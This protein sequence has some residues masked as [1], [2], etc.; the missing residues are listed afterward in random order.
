MYATRDVLCRSADH[1]IQRTLGTGLTT[2]RPSE[3]DQA[4][5][6]SFWVAYERLRS[7][8]TR[9]KHALPQIRAMVASSP[10]Q[11]IEIGRRISHDLASSPEVQAT[12]LSE[13]ATMMLKHGDVDE[14]VDTAIQAAIAERR[15]PMSRYTS[16]PH[17]VTTMV[18]VF[19]DSG[20]P[21]RAADILETLDILDD[22]GDNDNEGT[23]AY[24]R[25]LRAGVLAL[26]DRPV[27]AAELLSDALPVLT[28]RSG[29]LYGL[30]L[31]APRRRQRALF[32]ATRH[33]GSVRMLGLLSDHDVLNTPSGLLSILREHVYFRDGTYERSADRLIVDLPEFS[34]DFQWHSAHEAIEAVSATIS[35]FPFG[36]RRHIPAPPKNVAN[37]FIVLAV[38]DDLTEPD[39]VNT[40]IELSSLLDQNRCV[41]YNRAGPL[42]RKEIVPEI[43]LVDTRF[44][45]KTINT[46]VRP[47][48]EQAGFKRSSTRRFDMD[49]GGLG[50]YAVVHFRIERDLSV[51]CYASIYYRDLMQ[52]ASIE[53]YEN[54][55]GLFRPKPNLIWDAQYASIRAGRWK[56]NEPSE[57]GVNQLIDEVLDHVT[58]EIIPRVTRTADPQQEVDA[59]RRSADDLTALAA[60]PKKNRFGASTMREIISHMTDLLES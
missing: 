51:E 44:V 19:A 6:S 58:G 46:Q 10:D 53:R 32:A 52:P 59:I 57:D 37:A 40:M 22:G 41:F 2:S 33:G 20:R 56:C 29:Y 27:E 13:L 11:A 8:R 17:A 43:E 12:F 4:A 21:A 36:E 60:R 39:I 55:K 35:N 14:A 3:W 1:Y 23:R 34:L 24:R 7:P 38:G 54:A 45:E 50:H 48:L 16:N 26:S 47:L 30:E 42:S 49:R 28:E 25:V 15:S 18:D 31:S 9:V 5:Q